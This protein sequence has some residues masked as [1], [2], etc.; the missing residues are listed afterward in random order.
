M[1]PGVVDTGGVTAA[2]HTTA[3]PSVLCS[4][5]SLEVF[6]DSEERGGGEESAEGVGEGCADSDEDAHGKDTN[7]EASDDDVAAADA[8]ADPT[9]D[10]LGSGH[11]AGEG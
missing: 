8:V 7:K 2:Q 9:A 11:K 6:T 4:C 10:K 3:V 1:G 5:S